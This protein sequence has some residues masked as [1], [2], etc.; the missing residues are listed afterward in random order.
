MRPETAQFI[1]N[2]RKMLERGRLMLEVPLYED[3]GR[4]AYLACFHVAQALIFEREQRVLKTHR[5][6]Q[7]EF[8]RLM[9]EEPVIDGELR[10]FLSRAYR[11][12]TIADYDLGSSVV[13]TEADART[14]V[15]TAARFIEWLAEVI[16]RPSGGGD[17]APS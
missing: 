13:T 8:Q 2:A 3:A 16:A 4:A 14:A 5:G 9:Q 17:P 1:D 6:V 11:F 7:T 10:G 12:K 15:K